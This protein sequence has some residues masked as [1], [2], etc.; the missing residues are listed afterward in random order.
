MLASGA[1]VN[2]P[3]T[4]WGQT[5]LHFAAQ[6]ALYRAAD[7][8][9]EV[10]N[11]LIR[12]G[13]NVR[14]TDIRGNTPLHNAAIGGWSLHY[15]DGMRALVEAGADVA[16]ANAAGMTP[17]HI[18]AERGRADAVSVLVAAGAPVGMLSYDEETAEDL[19]RRNGHEVL[20]E[21]LQRQ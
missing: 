12:A 5:L 15:S 2:Q 21:F 17:L 6:G 20:A 13:A 4:T 18:A 3:V 19:A 7:R 9:V 10:V 1:D 14:A 8:T 16:A 11:A